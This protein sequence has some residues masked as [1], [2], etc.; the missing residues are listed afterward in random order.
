MKISHVEKAMGLYGLTPNDAD[1]RDLY[2]KMDDGETGN[3]TFDKFSEE[4]YSFVNVVFPEDDLMKSFKVFSSSTPGTHKVGRKNKRNPNSIKIED[5]E[6]IVETC[7]MMEEFDGWGTDE[8]R[9]QI[10]NIIREYIACSDNGR[11]T[12]EFG[13]FVRFMNKS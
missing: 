3:I 10:E 7:N 2:R 11:R 5:F 6:K 1:L 9:Q 12:W 4:L 13:N 8:S